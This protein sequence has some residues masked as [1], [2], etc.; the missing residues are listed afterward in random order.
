MFNHLLPRHIDN[1]YR[2]STLAVWVFGL[3]LLIKLVMSFN[4][5][6]NGYVIATSAHGIPLDTFPP[7][8][9]R[10]VVSLYALIGA[11]N[12]VMCVLCIL[13][14]VRYRS[15][16]PFMFALLLVELLSRRLILQ[17]LPIVRPEAAA[18]F[19]VNLVLFALMTVGVAL[20]LRTA[21]PRAEKGRA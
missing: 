12:F 16:I 14:V 17:F 18:S 7:A 9:A 11:S 6:F 5:I 4:T 21:Q 13:V 20:S 2:G 15:A 3:V 8:A 1:E 10:T 19:Y